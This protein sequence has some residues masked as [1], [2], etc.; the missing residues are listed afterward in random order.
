MESQ[1]LFCWLGA[2]DLKASEGEDVGNGPIAQA[3]QS[4]EYHEVVLLNDWLDE[5]AEP[6][7][8]WL[9]PQTTSKVSLQ[10]TPLSR[11]THF[12]EIYQAATRVVSGKLKEYEEGGTPVFHLSPGTPAMAAIWILLAKTRYAAQLIESSRNEGVRPVSV[13]FDISVDFIPD[14]LRKPDQTLERLAAGLP[15]E[16]PEFEHIIHRS[17]IMKRTVLKARRVAPRSIPVL[18]EGESGTGKELFARAIHE[19]SPRKGKPFV[20]IN[21]GAIPAE[22]VESELFGHEKGSFTGAISE[23]KGHFEAAHT[24]T[25]FLDELGELPKEMQVKLLRTIQEGEVRR[26]G[27]SKP[28]R[29]DV[30]IIAATNRSLIEEVGK[31]NFREDLF[32]RLAIAVIQL[33]P[34]REREG[35]I[36]LLIDTFLDRINR[37]SQNEPGYKH[38]KFSVNAKNILNSHPWPGNV[39][40]LQ[41]TL[42]RVAV[43]SL[44]EEINDQDIQESLLP[45]PHSPSESIL[46]RS[47][48]NGI[49]ITEIVDEVIIHYLRR[50]LER[51]NGNK[52]K[53]ARTLGLSN[54]QTLTNW[55]KKYGIE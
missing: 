28:L 3:V 34:L 52:T 22:L 37:E 21:C 26:I 42:T 1:I 19:A 32:Y 10:N 30:R 39:R 20:A 40:E 45:T 2:T 25:I 36:H 29:V 46:G 8:A 12:G 54:Y 23:R 31:G 15:A 6:Y 16:A 24:G 13:P 35:D 53:T 27:A 18:L 48:E 43:W 14:L 5:R 9:E 7:V 17:E 50:G 33:P 49:K 55:L 11:P 38:K 44:D 51:N 47:L 41:N 4:G